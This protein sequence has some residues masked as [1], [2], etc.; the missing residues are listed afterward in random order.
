MPF[1][2]V[3]VE[4]HVDDRKIDTI[5]C[6]DADLHVATFIS[7]TF[8]TQ[9]NSIKGKVITR[10]FSTDDPACPAK[11]TVRRI[12]HLCQQSHKSHSFFI[13][14]SQ[15]Q[16]HRNQGHQR[17]LSSSH[18]HHCQGAPNGSQTYRHQRLFTTHRR[19]HGAFVWPNLPQHH[20]YSGS[21]AQRRHAAIF[22]STSK[23]SDAPIRRD[24][25]QQWLSITMFLPSAHTSQ[26][27]N[28]WHLV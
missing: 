9:K 23:T 24:N 10:G 26:P 25:V 2:L 19:R 3:D 11:A 12:I 8:R 21:R 28:Y 17:Q 6:S 15:W 20:S 1:R 5:M 22:A 7:L 16:T 4:L 14:L 18:D 27:N 13:V